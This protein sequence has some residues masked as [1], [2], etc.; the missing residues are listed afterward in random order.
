MKRSL[1][2]LAVL[3]A[4]GAAMAQSSV[5]LYALVDLNLSNYSTGSK[6]NAV[7]VTKMNDGTANG[8]NGSRWG[9]RT[10]EDLGGGL[11]AGVVMESGV[12][13]DT[14]AAAQGG[15]AFGRQI[16]IRLSSTT[17]GELRMGRQV[18]FHDSIIGIGQ[19][20]TAGTTATWSPA[21][22]TNAGK[23]L[24][25]FFDPPRNNNIIQYET[26]DL[27][28]FKAAFEYAPGEGT[29][30]NFTA[31]R[32][33]YSKGPFNAGAAY[34]WNKDRTTGSDSNKITTIGANYNFGAFTVLGAVQHATDLTTT[35]GNGTGNV[36]SLIATGDTSLGTNTSFT[37][38]KT[39]GYT[40]GI[41]IPVSVATTV[42]VNYN[43]VKYESATGATANLGKISVSGRYAMS[44]NT[45]L[46]G[47]FSV[48]TGDLKD[49]ITENRVTQ[50]GLRT[51]F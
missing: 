32:G 11:S 2:A 16:F 47:G 7:N 40:V 43:L 9:I 27:S 4:S 33:I 5:T 19:S 44:K 37:V 13:A 10:N 3:A 22:V 36:T 15:L 38:G 17:A 8:L 42:D 20:M 48:A 26:A 1:V 51:M 49:Y 31:L 28:G 46:Y 30:D 45:F 24:V 23:S 39:N 18:D 12:N 21:P 6:S 14:G 34:S 41:E 25:G 35:A 29:A 50:I